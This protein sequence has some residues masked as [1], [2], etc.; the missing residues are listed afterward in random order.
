MRSGRA[1]VLHQGGQCK[2]AGG[3]ERIVDSCLEVNEYLVKVKSEIRIDEAHQLLLA[4]SQ[5]KQSCTIS[6]G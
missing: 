2:W 5:F 4:R 6:F 3:T 1:I